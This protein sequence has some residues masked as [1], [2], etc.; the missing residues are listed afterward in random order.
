MFHR[1]PT[2]R[3]A[4]FIVSSVGSGMSEGTVRLRLHNARLLSLLYLRAQRP[5]DFCVD[6]DY[7]LGMKH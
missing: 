6:R 4:L 1:R 3:A 7:G 2:A 5:L